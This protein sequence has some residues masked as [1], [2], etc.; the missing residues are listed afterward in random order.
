LDVPLKKE[1][2]LNMKIRTIAIIAA[3]LL[4]VSS[5]AIYSAVQT[6]SQSNI[7]VDYFAEET[8]IIVEDTTPTEATTEEFSVIIPEEEI[9]IFTEEDFVKTYTLE[10]IYELNKDAIFQV[11]RA[12][13]KGNTVDISN[14]SGFFIDPSGIAVTAY[15]AIHDAD[16]LTVFLDG[17]HRLLITEI[18]Y[19][20]AEN[21]IAVFQVEN[22]DGIEYPYLEVNVTDEP[23]QFSKVFGIGFPQE[24]GYLS[25]GWVIGMI[26]RK[27]C[28]DEDGGV[29]YY[30]NIIVTDMV[31]FNGNSGGPVFNDRNQAIGVIHGAFLN[32]TGYNAT[33]SL[34]SVES[35]ITE[36]L[37]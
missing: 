37:E 27:T 25:E 12:I 26:D 19:A 32:G 14:G 24:K 11:K 9:E 28:I 3:Y 7:S 18:Y 5:L 23:K 36:L 31:T 16:G 20:D 1:R 29:W 8:V 15:H 4:T 35:V 34:M 30:N 13:K 33:M 6:I 21:D 10:E 2:R 17:V 22:P